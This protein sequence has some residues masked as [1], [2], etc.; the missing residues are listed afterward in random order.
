MSAIGVP[1]QQRKLIIFAIASGLA[2][3][4]G[5]LS[6]QTNQFVGLN[7][8]SFELSGTVLIVLVL[9]GAGRLY[10]AFLGAPVYFAAQDILAKGDP[11]YW[12]FWLGLILI[13]VATFARGGILGLYDA[14]ARRFSAGRPAQPERGGL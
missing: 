13:V 6:A 3:L 7:V 8:L 11:V 12:L 14:L 2:G 4:A 10:G 1:V 5:A 9:G